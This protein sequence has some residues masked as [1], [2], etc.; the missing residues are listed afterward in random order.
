MVESQTTDPR[1]GTEEEGQGPCNSCWL[2]SWS[3]TYLL[4]GFTKRY[5][6]HH[7]L[8][9]DPADSGSIIGDLALWPDVFVVQNRA[10]EVHDAAAGQAAHH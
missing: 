8:R 9:C 6:P 3:F 7:V 1:E 5:S 2:D 4:L 10:M